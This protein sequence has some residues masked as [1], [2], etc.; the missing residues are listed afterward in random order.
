MANDKSKPPY[1]A[2]RRIRLLALGI[3]AA[4][5]GYSYGWHWL[6]GRVGAEADRMVAEEQA[7][8][9]A[10][11]CA[12]REVRGYP[13]RLEVF[14]TSFDVA[15]PADGLTV[16]AGGFRT[17]AQVYEPRNIIAELD[18]PVTVTSDFAGAMKFDWTLAQ[19]SAVLDDPVPQ[20]ASAVVDDLTVGFA[21]IERA[22]AAAHAETHLRRVE[23]NV[24]LAWRYE[25]LVI[26]AGLAGGRHLPAL[27]GDANMTIKNGV[28]L[29][30]GGVQSLRGVSGEI[31]RLAL[32]L[33]PERGLLVSGPFEIG[34]DGRVNATLDV[35]LV[36]P[37]G[38][39]QEL[40]PVFPEYSSQFDAF[41]AMPQKAGPDGTPE[42]KLP[43][44]ITDG[45]AVIG[46][47]PVGTIPPVD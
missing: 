10:I 12:D 30:A 34:M 43:V 15:R 47:I 2:G 29:A 28:A 4:G 24:D 19:A 18:S 16:K 14:C 26:D 22:L 9:T 41:A 8:G 3:V 45:N 32:L 37:A 25:G 31:H 27:S 7:R 36:D 44:R 46:F 40:K 38:F 17:A 33:T 6:A 42:L 21:G 20:H 35:F 39:A 13:F 5:I 1:N 23:D 11:D